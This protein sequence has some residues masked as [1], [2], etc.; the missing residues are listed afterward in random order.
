MRSISKRDTIGRRSNRRLS[1]E[2]LET[3]CVLTS[4][5]LDLSFGKAGIVET[6]FDESQSWGKIA[7]AT[8]IQTD[9]KIVATGDGALARYSVNGEL[10]L[11]FGSKGKVAIPFAARDVAIHSD[12]RIVV[13]GSQQST[14][15]MAVARFLANGQID[16]TFDGDG[17]ATTDLGPGGGVTGAVT[18][19]LVIQADGKIVVAG[20]GGTGGQSGVAAVRYL[21]NGSLDPTFGV[22]GKAIYFLNLS[23]AAYD[24]ALQSD[25]RIVMVGQSLAVNFQQDFLVV[26]LLTD[27]KLDQSF[28]GD[29]WLTRHFLNI[30]IASGVA[31]Q[32]NGSIVVSGTIRSN[33]SSVGAYVTRLLSDGRTDT[34]FNGFG[35]RT[36][37]FQS[38]GSGSEDLFV[39]E[40]GKIL[41]AGSTLDSFAFVQYNADGSLDSSFGT[42]GKVTLFNGGPSFSGS[43]R[44]I[45]RQASGSFVVSGVSKGSFGLARFQSN[46]AL[47]TSFG[48]NGLVQT[49][50]G[51]S[52]DEVGGIAVQPN[53]KTVVV[54]QS[55]RLMSLARYNL[56][57]SLDAS[58]GTGG[59]VTLGFGD[60]YRQVRA[61]SV[62]L[63]SDGKVVVAGVAI[64]VT[65]D[66][67]DADFLVA[68]FL[69]NGALDTSFSGD[70]WLTTESAGHEQAYSVA[71]Q[72][73]G[74]IVVGGSDNIGFAIVRYNADGK[75]DTSF[76]GDG[77]RSIGFGQNFISSGIS[78]VLVQSNG[79]IVGVGS[80]FYSNPGAQSGALAAVR[81]LPNGNNDLSFNGTGRLVDGSNIQRYAF[82]AA[83]QTDGS[84]LVAGGSDFR[85]NRGNARINMAVTKL[86][87]S[88][89][90]DSTFGNNGTTEILFPDISRGTSIAIQPN[91]RIVVGGDSRG[92]YAIA[93]LNSDGS[94]DSS[95]AGD[96]KQTTDLGR[97]ELL[98]ADL[99][100]LP[101]GRILLAGSR[102]ETVRDQLD[103]DFVLARYRSDA[104]AAAAIL[105]ARN[106]NGAIEIKDQWL[107]DDVIE[108]SRT[109]TALV[110][111]DKT[112][113]SRARFTVSGLPSISGNGTKQISIPLSLIQGSG[114]PLIINTLQGDD[115]VE[116]NTNAS[117]SSIIPTTGLR[118]DLGIGNDHLGLVNSVTDNVWNFFGGLSGSLGVGTLGTVSFTGLEN[119]DGGDGKDLFR[120]I[121]N[122]DNAV[123][124]LGGNGNGFDT[125]E[126]ERNADMRLRSYVSSLSSSFTLDVQSVRPQSYVITGL[127]ALILTGG[128]SNNEID[129]TPFRGPAT[130][131]GRGGNDRLY[132][133]YGDDI[134]KG[135]TG[136]DLLFG[137]YG[138]DRDTLYGDAGNDILMGGFGIDLLYGGTGQDLITG[139][140]FAS[141]VTYAPA[142]ARDAILAAW[143][144]NE[145]Y[146]ARIERLS[147]TGVG[148]NNS[149]KLL[150]NVEAFDDFEVDTIFGEA[151]LDWFFLKTAGAYNELNVPVGGLRDLAAG[152]V[153]TS[154]I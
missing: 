68:R 130:I 34:T 78:K 75:L 141:L 59:K 74:K 97:A 143:F 44:S 52:L 91:G 121:G 80:V 154:L 105:V 113:D 48:R 83:L 144:S 84:I 137:G 126:V 28:D 73:D 95:F 31:V 32:S 11:S 56:N 108:V 62:A 116:L 71:I 45:S 127:D 112:T 60:Q 67:A 33:G 148:P 13:V 114:Q 134:M 20:S 76:S 12:G 23:D 10:D 17:L 150:P 110:L 81:L 135:G 41:L 46:G 145:S 136:N 1:I 50:F 65:G 103:S 7:Y 8:A 107:R 26:R 99:A 21:A 125:L 54:G 87:S 5:E 98:S 89:I 118:I 51:P 57:G 90:R 139:S 35:V 64:T 104:E 24:L 9:G 101:D 128:S 77:K 38:R 37:N 147:V 142:E 70:G 82:D 3:R 55:G 29:G 140:F 16:P 79:A 92:D 151:G 86:L 42:D 153:V 102:R 124:R 40:T 115:R 131:D 25:G 6:E 149:I 133:G 69:S 129:V 47:D 109:S 39:S 63:Q 18:S 119:A 27:G 122:I 106:A 14:G 138:S 100:L 30:D 117:V 58:F 111:S 43:A 132:G 19:S 22:Q 152:E 53:G 4:G 72:P 94:P 120:L 123:V 2:S 85:P 66:S 96:G 49:D 61:N 36:E 146:L 15:F 88:G 93:R